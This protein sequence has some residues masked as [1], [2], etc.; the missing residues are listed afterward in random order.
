MTKFED[1]S[2]PRTFP[3]RDNWKTWPYKVLECLLMLTLPEDSRSW[4]FFLPPAIRSTICR[5]WHFNLCANS[6]TSILPILTP[7]VNIF[8]TLEVQAVLESLGSSM[9]CG[10]YS[11]L[12]VCHIASRLPAYQ[13][14]RLLRSAGRHSTRSVDWISIVLTTIAS[15][16]LGNEKMDVEADRCG[17]LPCQNRRLHAFPPS[18]TCAAKT[19][20]SVLHIIISFRS[21]QFWSDFC[22]FG[23]LARLQI[24]ATSAK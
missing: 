9:L 1:V 23:L 17:S 18:P 21:C 2:D 15:N 6:W 16:V 11:R 13:V 20:Y 7:L 14:V 22:V 24:T 4:D 12:E 5:A 10:T 8:S 3:F 19:T